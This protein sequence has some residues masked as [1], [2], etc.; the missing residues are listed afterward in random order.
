LEYFYDPNTIVILPSTNYFE[1]LGVSVNYDYKIN[2]YMN[3]KNEIKWLKQ[4]QS[5]YTFCTA[6]IIKPF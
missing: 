1:A 2:K 6:L 4:S 3:I 5:T